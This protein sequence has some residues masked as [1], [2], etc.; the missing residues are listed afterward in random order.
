MGGGGSNLNFMDRW[1]IYFMTVNKFHYG[2][3]KLYN[4]FKTVYNVFMH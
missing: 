2:K 1:S 3:K 4:F